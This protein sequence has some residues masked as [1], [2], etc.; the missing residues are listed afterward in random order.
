MTIPVLYVDDDADI[1]EIAEMALSLDPDLEVRTSASGSDAL[2]LVEQWKPQLIL[3]DFMM[4]DLD[5]PATLRLLRQNSSLDEVPVVFITARTSSRDVE[6]LLA[7]GAAGVLAKPF[8]VMTL[9]AQ[10]REFVP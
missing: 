2:A 8:D 7:S 4:P 5:G 3:L 9:A 6:S 1:R 10:C